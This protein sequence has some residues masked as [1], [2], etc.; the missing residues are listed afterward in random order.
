MDISISLFLMGIK[1]KEVLISLIK[2]FGPKYI[3]E[4]ISSQDKNVLSDEYD[5]LRTICL[6]NN[7]PFANRRTFIRSNGD[8]QIAIGWRWLINDSENLIILH[9]SLLPKYRGFAP[10]VNSLINGEPKIGVTALYASEKYDRGDIITQMSVNIKYPIKI[11]DAIKEVTKLY[12]E[13]VHLVFK[14]LVNDKR[15]NAKP[16]DE[17]KATYSLWRD[18]YD[19]K[20]K[21]DKSAKEIRRFVDAL[22]FPYK[23]AYSF[24]R[25]DKVRV[26]KVEEVEGVLIENEGVG[27]VIHF[28]GIYPV[29]VCGEGLLKILEI[30]DGDNRSILPLKNFR[31]RFM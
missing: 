15:M 18:E 11:V 29:V 1:G 10:L 7:I 27:K 8:F 23:G 26:L 14:S 30:I 17:D 9:D 24:I 13:V 25:D 4:V 16:Q 28:D 3:A 12:V 22:G 20:I 6:E 21:W 19:Y 5:E 2:A 31:T